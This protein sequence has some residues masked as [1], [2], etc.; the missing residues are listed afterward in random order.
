METWTPTTS[1]QQKWE[2]IRLGNLIRKLRNQPKEFEQYDQI[3]QT[4]LSEWIIEKAPKEVKVI[5]FYIP[6]KP[7]VREEA[8]ST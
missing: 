7:V 8:E 4:Q 6:Y 1:Q 5:E 3:I 2:P